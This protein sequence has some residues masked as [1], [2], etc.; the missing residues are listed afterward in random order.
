MSRMGGRPIMVPSGVKIKA[1]AQTLYFEGPKGKSS[2]HIG[3]RVQ[4][5]CKD[6]QIEVK[7]QSDEKQDR[8]MHGTTRSLIQ[9]II[10]GITQGFVKELEIQGVGYKAQIQGKTLTLTLGFS[11]PVNYAVPEGVTVETPKPTQIIIKGSDKQKVGLCASQIRGL[12]PPEPYKGKGIRYAG[13][14]VRKKAGK[15]VGK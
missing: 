9:N 3:P 15:T 4:V 5:I 11:H 12:R 6:G 13:E 14:Y 8:A 7:R 1:E 10:L 2:F